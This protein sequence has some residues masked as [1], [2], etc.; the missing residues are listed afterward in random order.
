MRFFQ[1]TTSQFFEFLSLEKTCIIVFLP[2]WEYKRQEYYLKAIQE[3]V[4]VDQSSFAFVLK[5]DGNSALED[6]LVDQ[7]KVISLPYLAFYN[8]GNFGFGYSLDSNWPDLDLSRL[9]F[10]LLSSPL[11]PQVMT[12]ITK[13]LFKEEWFSDD[14]PIM[15]FIS[16]DR[17]SV[18]KS[19]V[20]LS[21]LATLIDMGIQPQNLAY[22]KPV[23][24]CEAE[25]PVTIF[26]QKLGIKH[27]SIGPVVFYKGFTRSYLSGETDSSEVL[28]DQAFE[29]VYE[30]GIGKKLVVVDGVGYPSVGSI[31]NISNAH[32]ARKLNAPVLLIGKSGVGDAV[33]SYNL[34][35]AYFE[36]FGV[37]VLGGIFNKLDLTGFYNLE[38][39]REA[40]SLYFDKFKPHQRP[41]GFIPNTLNISSATSDIPIGIPEFSRFV[42][43]N[44]LLYDIWL[45]QVLLF[46][47]IYLAFG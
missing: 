8:N 42:D 34:N 12:N 6:Y 44:R 43:I 46:L 16:G 28:L 39:C 13:F 23:T 18:G 17:S 45:Y 9:D 15:L 32:V 10:N 30:I 41:Y 40:V 37:K 19:T 36:S 20:C 31:C 1:I 47:R 11:S 38:S 4:S 14:N 33:D 21:L 22:I 3:K 7:I 25:Q 2:A 29:A 27:Q 5:F 35:S 24:Q 26:C